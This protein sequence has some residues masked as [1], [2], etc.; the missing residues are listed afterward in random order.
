MAFM[1]CAHCICI[2]NRLLFL[3]TDYSDDTDFL[4]ECDGRRL[5]GSCRAFMKQ[6]RIVRKTIGFSYNTPDLCQKPPAAFSPYPQAHHTL[7]FIRVIRE[8]M[9]FV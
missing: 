7:A 6:R 8:G 4:G 1:I 5:G 9:K 2:F 3:T